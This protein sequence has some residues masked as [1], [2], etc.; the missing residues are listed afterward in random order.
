MHS[1]EVDFALD[2]GSQARTRPVEIAPRLAA[3]H[4]MRSPR[5]AAAV[6]KSLFEPKGGVL[7]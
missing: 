5:N 4:A 1:H 3:R 2:P 7:R 6:G